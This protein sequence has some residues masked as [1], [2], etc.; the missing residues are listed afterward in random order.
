MLCC[1]LFCCV[2]LCC[3]AVYAVLVCCVVL[4]CLSRSDVVM[5]T[6]AQCKLYMEYLL[7]VGSLV[8]FPAHVG[9]LVHCFLGNQVT[10]AWTSQLV[11]RFVL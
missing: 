7:R 3:I 1:V 2:V 5:H 11:K 4:L 6:H 8:Q 9:Q 10:D